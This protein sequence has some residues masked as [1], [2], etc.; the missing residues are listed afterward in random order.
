MK[1]GPQ[2]QQL[3]RGGTLLH[4]LSL[5]SCTFGRIHTFYNGV[6][7]NV[8]PDY[9]L[10]LDLEKKTNCVLQHNLLHLPCG[11]KTVFNKQLNNQVICM[12]AFSH[13]DL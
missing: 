8:N 9:V 7:N 3:C 11:I 13:H 1:E 2:K 4:S 5:N 10:I 12:L 6:I